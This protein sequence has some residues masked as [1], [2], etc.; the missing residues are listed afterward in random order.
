M[1]A[2]K[3]WKIILGLILIALILV[4]MAFSVGVYM[5]K[6]GKLDQNMENLKYANQA[7]PDQG[8]DWQQNID[9]RQPDM[10]GRLAHKSGDM[11]TVN[12]AQGIRQ[13]MVNDQTTFLDENQQ[14]ISP[15]DLKQGDNLAI[16]GSLLHNGQTT[17][18]ATSV[19]RI[20][21]LP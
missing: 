4:V 6:N 3:D 16:S 17:F 10:L 9:H 20:S 12:T 14:L 2:I 18:L 5:G 13:V 7:R 15:D 11:L 21:A 1:V 8:A 19:I